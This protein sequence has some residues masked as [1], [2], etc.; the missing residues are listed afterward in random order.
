MAHGP[1][2]PFTPKTITV[3]IGVNNTV[4]WTNDDP[5][6][7]VHTVTSNAAGLFDSGQMLPGDTFTCT[8]TAAGTYDYHCTYHPLMIGTI[9]VKSP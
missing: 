2:G 5:N 6:G 1:F 9:I 3:V 8:F 4:V 7:A